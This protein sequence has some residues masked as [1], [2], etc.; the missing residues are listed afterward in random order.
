MKSFFPHELL[1]CVQ[2]KLSY[3]KKTHCKW[4]ICGLFSSCTPKVQVLRGGLWVK[5]LSQNSHLYGFFPSWAISMCKYLHVP[6]VWTAITTPKI[7]VYPYLFMY[8]KN[9]GF[10]ASF[11]LNG[12]V[13]K[14]TM[15]WSLSFMNSFNMIFQF[16]LRRRPI[17]ANFTLV[18]FVAYFLH[19]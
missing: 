11:M 4:N 7:F 16:G 3:L 12:C 18:S 15:E 14:V 6:F 9:I 10:K 5:H 19:E 13:A 17:F 8:W 1:Q 2:S